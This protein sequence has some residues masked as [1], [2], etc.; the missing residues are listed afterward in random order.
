[1]LRGGGFPPVSQH[2]LLRDEA[3]D[4]CRLL[5]FCL[6]RW[7]NR[8]DISSL[9]RYPSFRKECIE[10]L[11]RAA[12][13]MVCLDRAIVVKQQTAKFRKMARTF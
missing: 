3:L 10:P 1:M 12:V 4:V 2:V 7:P 13:Y 6:E 9:G 8:D 5:I 11:Y